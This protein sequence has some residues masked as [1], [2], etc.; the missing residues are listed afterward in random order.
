MQRI[1]VFAVCLLTFSNLYSQG[2]S[3]TCTRTIELGCGTPCVTINA[4]I[5][6]LRA[7]SSNYKIGDVSSVA[8]C[9]PEVD[10]GGP[11]PSANLTVDDTYSNAIAIGFP[12]PFYGT[13]Y[14]NLIVSTNGYVSF[15][16][17]LAGGFSHWDDEGNLPNTLYDEALIMG[18]YHDLNPATGTSPTQKVKYNTFGTAPT[19][20]WVLSFF[21]LPLF[22]CTASIENTHQI[23][24]HESSGLIEVYIKD[25]QICTTWNDGHA[26][27]GL[28]N[29]ARNLGI[30]VPNR[31]MSDAPW[32]TV[33]MN[34][35]WR[36]V[37]RDGPSIFRGPSELIDLSTGAVVSTSDTTRIDDNNLGLAFPNVCPAPNTT[38]TYVV[39]TRW[40]SITDAAATYFSTD[41]II[42][43]RQDG[44][45]LDA[46]STQTLCG[47]STGTITATASGGTPPYQY[48]INLGPLQ[49]SGTFTGLAAG[50]Y[51]IVG[52]DATGCTDTISVDVTSLS[53]IPG[54]ATSTATGCPG[55]NNGTI[56]VTPGGGTAPYTYSLDGGASQASNVFTGVSAGAHTVVFTDVNG[57]SGTVSVNVTAGTALTSTSTVI[58][59]SCAGVNNGQATI[60]PTS[61]SAPYTFSI[62]GGPFQASNVFTGLSSGSH[63]VTIRDNE[64]C[65]GT[66][67]IFISAGSGLIASVIPSPASCTGVNNGSITINVLN[68]TAPY[69]FALDG[70]TPQAGNT[71]T[72]VAAGAHTVTIE[73]A[74]GCVTNI[75]TNVTSGTGITGSGTAAPTA[76]PGVD[77]GSITLTSGTGD[78]PF[79]YSIDGGTTFQASNVFN[80]LAPGAY[81]AVIRDNNG[82]TFTT[83]LTVNA[84]TSITSTSTSTPTSCPGVDNGTITVTPTSG[85]APHTF[86][87]DGGTTYQASATFNGLAS[88]TYTITIR[89]DSGCTG[90]VDATVAPGTA[91]GLT[92]TAT[93]TACT[94][95]STG[96]I[97]ATA[98]SG[99]A[100][101]EYSLDGTTF[102][103]SNIFNNQAEGT[104]TVTIR[105]ANGCTG[106][107][108]VNVTANA[109][110]TLTA[111]TTPTACSGASTG[112]ITVTPAGGSNP[113][114]F[115]MDGGTT[116]QSSSV[117]SNIADGTFTITVRDANGCTATVDATVGA[118]STYSGTFTSTPTA[119]AGVSTGSVTITPT[120]GTAPY[121]YSIDG[122]TTYQPSNTFNSLTNGSYTITIRDANGCTGTVDATVDAG[123]TFSGTTTSTETA[124]TGVSTGS[125]TVTPNGGTAP[126][127]YSIDG[128]TT[129]QSSNTFN[130][131]AEGSYTIIIRDNNGCTGTVNEDVTAGPALTG[132]ATHTSSTCSTAPDGT[133]TVTPTSGTG[134]YTYSLD[135]V[136]FQ[137][138]DVFTGLLPNTYTIT[139]RDA[140]GCTG[141]VDETVTPGAGLSGTATST[142]TSCPGVSN[143]SITVTPTAGIGLAPYSYS[144][145]GGTSQAASTFNGVSAGAHTVVI[146]DANGCTGTVNI[147]VGEG[148]PITGTAAPVET[149][150]AG[151]DNGSVVITS[152]TGTAPYTYALDGGTAQASPSF[153][154]LSAGGHVV[155][156][157][158]ANGCT[159]NIS[160]TV[161]AGPGFTATTAV[162]DASCPGVDNGSVNI[163]T[164]DGTAP[165]QYNIDGGAYQ[166]GSTFNGLSA[167]NHVV[168]VRDANG[169]VTDNI[170][171]VVG[172]GAP[173]TG[174]GDGTNT[175]C[176]GVNDGTVSVT[177]ATGTA[178]YTY[179]L[180]G[181][182][183]Q[184][185]NTFTGLAPDTYT[186]TFTD[187]N[188]C[189]GSVD[190]IIG[191]GSGIS[192]TVDVVNT[193]CPGVNNG[194]ITVTPTSGNAPYQ[195]A[196]NGGTPQ[197]SNVFTNLAPGNYTIS[198][199]D[200]LGCSGTNTATIEEGAVLTSTIN[201]GN[202]QCAD[203]NDGT[204]E[205][206]ATTG[207]AP[208]TYSIN[209]GTPQASNVFSSLA[210]GNYTIAFT[211]AIGCTG[212]NTQTLVTNAPII[213]TADINDPLCFGS[214][215]G[216]V[217]ITATGGVAPYTYSINNGTTYQAVNVFD[218]LTDG[219]YTIRVKDNVNCTK[220]IP[221]VLTQPGSLTATAVSTAPSTCQGG[222][223][224]IEVTGIGGTAP[225][226]YSVDNGGS[227]PFQSSPSFNV[228][229][230]NY[231]LVTVKDDNGCTATAAPVF[232]DEIDNMFLELGADTTICEGSSVTFN[233]QTNN[234][235]SVFNWTPNVAL[236]DNTIKNATASPVDTTKYFLTAQWGACSR[237]DSI[238]INVKWKPIPDAGPAQVRICLNDST[239]ISGTVS[240]T[241]GPVTL[242]W[243]PAS[244]VRDPN[245]AT[246]MAIPQGTQLYTLTATDDYG[247]NFS[248]TDTILVIMQPAV[249]AYAG[250][251]TLLI[252]NQAQNL[253]GSGGELYQ[254]STPSSGVQIVNPTSQSPTVYLA[255]DARFF[256]KVTDIAGCVGYDTV[257]VQVYQG[258]DYLVPNAFTPNG[259]GLN[260]VFRAIPVGMTTPEYFRIFNRYGQVVFETNQYMKGWDGRYKGKLQQT[261]TYVWILK[262]KDKNGRTIEQKGTVLLI[263]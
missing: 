138:S 67:S 89:D 185:S 247:C 19:R 71:F 193:S 233:P 139:I 215:D 26:M 253:M 9:Y 187:A 31:R 208:Y 68:G 152:T 7:Q 6:D 123:S 178:P 24:L 206:I 231:T 118:G 56:T 79:T 218:G 112:S 183:P 188:G 224:V 87:I 29:F 197:A 235:T 189:S 85:T 219:A 97:T 74:S 124:C 17:A 81:T 141:T 131:L 227:Y 190:V 260:D 255:N 86:S 136:T 148:D 38:T 155:I 128:G 213:L 57:C 49:N 40:Q 42:V 248:V 92:A 226:T 76:C 180:N 242:T 225:Y 175:T 95:V 45:P 241:S 259:D 27:V 51:T 220:D 129:Y 196:I 240:H 108:T 36:F 137:A 140:I 69:T 122:G 177:S 168:T 83:N 236:N 5:P 126:Y 217:T 158:D 84:G 10:P 39:R 48:S 205:V 194:T 73:D 113:F 110:F 151:V 11:G 153:T 4:T 182:T 164:V 145:D 212:T 250:G 54:T 169:C 171:F 162:T 121:E 61:G 125:I 134:P 52:I 181:G 64:G 184:A 102:Q 59:T 159:A 16:T 143:G 258:P 94:S 221:V 13:V 173:I 186:I 166:N 96:V 160:F 111:T 107:T 53:D 18:P 201:A 15:N 3:Y 28:Q 142:P 207:T 66:R 210:P 70:G 149:S 75:N 21:K 154:S 47:Q 63:T 165:F 195:Y 252:V 238:T 23:I 22:N 93:P 127:E 144:L 245:A 203:I 254:W 230:G 12:F 202:P 246:T 100:P 25:K 43:T 191:T 251:D 104:Y 33:G 106:T 119:C 135:A 8:A 62:D 263:N 214:D 216:Q 117:F 229:T 256:L 115:S 50:T 80:G 237:T 192:S 249:P 170:A 1:L 103:S 261:G 91:I 204:I 232:V 90:T 167:G 72:G 130:G 150:C 172:T 174:S 98:T 234:E 223:G 243:S 32:G 157:T 114:E 58:G 99:T 132:T 156:M 101:Y 179:S 82:C 262:G 14:N 147:T 163:T 46:T 239:L 55:V 146:T 88:G 257:Y 161:N 244:L 199:S 222:D 209:G 44:L 211:D 176:P 77:N 109:P 78:A 20:K 228:A 60:T 198:I 41:T 30:M 2:V 105:D 35:I 65:T 200:V 133:I 34:E 37:P 120:G 116:Y